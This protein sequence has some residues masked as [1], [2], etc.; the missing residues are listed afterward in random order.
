MFKVRTLTAGSS[1]VLILHVQSLSFLG[2]NIL[3]IFLPV[4]NNFRFTD[5]FSTHVSL[6]Y[7]IT[8]LTFRQNFNL[9]FFD[10]NLLLNIFRL[11][12][13]TLM[14]RGILSLTS[15]S[16]ELSPF[17]TDP[18]HLQEFILVLNS[19]SLYLYHSDHFQSLNILNIQLLGHLQLIQ[20]V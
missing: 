14:S 17:T 19:C 15:S 12:W 8:G 13:Y 5:S 10:I 9:A 7:V 3:L 18:K 2:P 11:A 20:N 16:I 1:L 6:E 4:T